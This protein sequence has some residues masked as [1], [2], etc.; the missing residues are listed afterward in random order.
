VITVLKKVLM[1]LAI[2]F[3]AYF[4]ITKPT[5]AANAVNGAWS[6][7]VG[8]FEAIVEFLMALF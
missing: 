5:A 8:I 7:V 6:A 4:L 3:A 2:A 1:V